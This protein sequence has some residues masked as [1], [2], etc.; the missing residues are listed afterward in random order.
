M[1]DFRTR[2]FYSAG[3]LG[4]AALV[5]SVSFFLLYF[6]T[7]V[8]KVGP[9]LASSALL[10]GQ[11][12]DIINDPVVGWLS[13]R[14]RSRFGKRRVFLIFG[15]LP[16]CIVTVLLWSLPSGTSPIVA[17]VWIAA[18]Y[19][20]FDTFFSLCQVPYFAM[21][22]ELVSDYDRRTQLTAYSGAAAG[23]GF[24]FGSV[25]VTL[26]TEAMGQTAQAYRAAGLALGLLALA[27]T[28]IVAWKVKPEGKR[29]AQASILSSVRHALKNRPF[30]HLLAS[31]ALARMGFTFLMTLFPFFMEHAMGSSI[32]IT[33][34]MLALMLS[35]TAFVFLWKA[36]SDRKSKGFS[37]ASGLCLAGL[38]VLLIYFLSPD[39]V[40]GFYLLVA[41]SG[42]GLS[43]HWVMPFAMVPDAVEHEEVRTGERKEGMYFGIYGLADKVIRTAGIF[44]TGWLLHFFGYSG[45][46]VMQ[47]DAVSG[48]RILFGPVSAALLF[49]AALMLYLYPLDRQEHKENLSRI[50]KDKRQ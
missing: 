18:S 16:L 31:F 21:I 17:F 44:L 30:L 25:S 42:I 6:Y 49:G 33:T 27:T 14:N 10:I 7:D 32:S 24:L 38:A 28:W 50:A 26:F 29:G 22:P 2:I 1:L 12:W 5:S 34:A 40:L 3:N 39:D 37:Y 47:P 11:I 45:G 43:A 9:A 20:L 41:L 48:I 4:F 19:L 13:D 35:I 23:L 15:A 46:G 36:V 8:A